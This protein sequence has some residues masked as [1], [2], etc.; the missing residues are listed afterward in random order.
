MN[1][2]PPK[3]ERR[4][5]EPP[6][7]A[8][9]TDPEGLLVSS[10]G[11]VRLALTGGVAS[12]KSTVSELLSVFG[13]RIVDF[14][15][16]AREA[17]APDGPC[18]EA[19]RLIFG[20]KSVGKDGRLDRAFIA[21]RM[22]KDARLREALEARVHPYTWERMLSELKACGDCPIIVA[23]VPLLFEARL[24]PLFRPT[25]LCFATPATQ[26]RRLLDR[27]PELSRRQ[28]LRVIRSQGAA[29]DKLRLA[30]AVINNDGP[31]RD[32]IR[33]TKALWDRLNS[34]VAVFPPSRA[35]AGAPGMPV[36]ANAVGHRPAD[37]AS[38]E[39]PA[40][41]ASGPERTVKEGS[42][43]EAPAPADE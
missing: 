13:A 21:K 26:L 8:W 32:T 29:A 19:A 3:P 10:P 7:P 33:Q 36:A 31:I 11:R 42:G 9:A 5:P 43:P 41:A 4:P 24:D 35:Q 6:P 17:L 18:F 14:D 22:F 20:P 37:R 40:P 30:D 2:T 28:A 39:G 15:L 25:V 16:L 1:P 34:P 23:D 12:G 38:P 27:N